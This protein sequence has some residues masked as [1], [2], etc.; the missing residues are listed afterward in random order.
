[1]AA[2]QSTKVPL[3]CAR[4]GTSVLLVPWQLRQGRRYCSRLCAGTQGGRDEARFLAKIETEPNTGCWIW[5]ASR[6]SDGYGTF[7]VGG[8]TV[9]A[10]RWSYE[11]FAGPIPPDKEID[12][13]L[14][15]P[16]I[17]IGRA[18]VN[19]RHLRPTTHRAN[20]LRSATQIMAIHARKTHCINGHPFSS[21]NLMLRPEGRRC[22]TCFMEGVARRRRRA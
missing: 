9:S 8:K 3:V 13:Y 21:E 1:M 10:H 15:N 22:R 5:T 20:T 2:R 14:Y 17:C 7:G 16:G 19:Y 6:C 11:N 18:C 12:H 4:C